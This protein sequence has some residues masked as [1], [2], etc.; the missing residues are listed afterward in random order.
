MKGRTPLHDIAE[1]CTS[2]SEFVNE[3]VPISSTLLSGYARTV[4][5]NQKIPYTIFKDNTLISVDEKK[6]IEEFLLKFTLSYYVPPFNTPVRYEDYQHLNVDRT[7]LKTVCEVMTEVRT[8]LIK[9]TGTHPDLNQLDADEYND[10]IKDIIKMRTRYD[11][12]KF[13]TF[14]SSNKAIIPYNFDRVNGIHQFWVAYPDLQYKEIVDTSVRQILKF[15]VGNCDE[16]SILAMWLLKQALPNLNIKMFKIKH[17]DHV[18]LVINAINHDCHQ[19]DDKVLICDPLFG[20]IIRGCDWM[21]LDGYVNLSTKEK[22]INASVRLNPSNHLEL[23]P[24]TN[25]INVYY[26]VCFNDHIDSMINNTNDLRYKLLLNFCRPIVYTGLKR[27]YIKSE[28][29]ASFISRPHI[30]VEIFYRTKI[31]KIME[32]GLLNL[33][34]LALL[35][36]NEIREEMSKLNDIIICTKLS[37]SSQNLG[38]NRVNIGKS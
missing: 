6:I 36:D 10:V 28:D 33:A 1:N 12:R 2:L 15:R 25:Q 31:Y 22:R 14:F 35:N 27:A 9:A 3:I 7:L 8:Q 24:C 37:M 5:E 23:H 19:W 38:V 4:D 34:F 16:L 32:K 11:L 30:F 17:V 26:F 29:V 13:A 21:Q 20:K 18:V